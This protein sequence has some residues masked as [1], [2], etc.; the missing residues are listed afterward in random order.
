MSYAMFI[1]NSGE[2]SSA[3]RASV[4]GTEGRGFK[5]HRSPQTFFNFYAGLL[6]VRSHRHSPKVRKFVRKIDYC[7]ATFR[8]F[9]TAS[10][11]AF[12]SFFNLGAATFCTLF[13]AAI[14]TASTV[15]V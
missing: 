15:C 12:S 14:E 6:K 13:M 3:G 11:F 10:I 8:T 9:R 7:Q 2:R 4:C 5:S 1:R